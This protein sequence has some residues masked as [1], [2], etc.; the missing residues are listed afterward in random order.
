MDKGIQDA[1]PARLYATLAGGL[2]VI[3]GIVGFFYSSSFGSPGTTGEVF[4]LFE[5]NGWYNVAHIATGA[6]GLLVAGYAPRQ[7]ALSMGTIYATIA[8]WGLIVGSGESI[9]GFLPVN[10]GNNFLNLA[11]GA[12]GICAAL[13]TPRLGTTK[14]PAHRQRAARP[15]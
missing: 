11:L 15:T 12:L 1:S 8:I 5:V 6:A 14:P 4:G 9:L 2:L 3:V 13:A 7:Y 10:D